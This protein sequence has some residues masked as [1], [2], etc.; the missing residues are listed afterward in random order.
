MPATVRDLVR[1]IASDLPAGRLVRKGREAAFKGS[2][3]NSLFMGPIAWVAGKI[4]GKEK[5]EKAIYERF[6]RPLKN[7]DERA[8]RA[9]ANAG[10]GKS[11]FGHVDVLPTGRKMGGNPA[12]IEHHTHSLTE[13]IAKASRFATPMLAAMALG[14]IASKLEARPMNGDG[15][16]LAKE[17]AE[18]LASFVTRDQAIK[19]A[20]RLVEE[21]RCKP[22]TTNAE[23]EEKVAFIVEKGPELVEQALDLGPVEQSVG[24]LTQEKTASAED[25]ATAFFHKLQQ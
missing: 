6:H 8:G 3:T 5:V 14:N 17:A 11:L 2:G 15:K 21:R 18:K 24:E 7:L 22:F 13:P 4:K 23:F 1:R 16:Q 12:F 19:L 10:V 20:F 9:L 25:P